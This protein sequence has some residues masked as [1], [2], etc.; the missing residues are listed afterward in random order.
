[1]IKRLMIVLLCALIAAV[2]NDIGYRAGFKE[3][4]LQEMLD[5]YLEKVKEA[6]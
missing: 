2:S 5:C 3:G 4:Q 1:M 6:K